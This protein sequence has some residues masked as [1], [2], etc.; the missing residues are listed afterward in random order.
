MGH[1]FV[2][3]DLSWKRSARVH[4]LVDTGATHSILPADLADELGIVRSPRPTRVRLAD[5]TRRTMRV[6]AVL[7]RLLG[8]ATPAVT[9]IRF[10]APVHI[11]L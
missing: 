8:R 11:R 5:G 9:T 3:A 4:M 1:V 6:G 10:S 2:D 7:V